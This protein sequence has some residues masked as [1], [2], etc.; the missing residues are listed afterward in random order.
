MQNFERATFTT[1]R[2]ME[3]FTEKELQMRMGYEKPLWS[4]V[5]L[6]ELVDN[7]LDACENVGIQPEIEVTVEPDSLS[8]KDNGPGLPI[9]TLTRS[10]NYMVRVSDGS[11]PLTNSY[12]L[13]CEREGD[14]AAKA[15]LG[16]NQRNFQ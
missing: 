12:N 15:L 9:S 1:H 11:S 7:A 8:V 5:L 14:S 3:F 6:K 4:L 10:L 13:C 16:T 2:A